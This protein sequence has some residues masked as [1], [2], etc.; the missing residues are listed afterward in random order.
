MILRDK[1]LLESS[2]IEVFR[3]EI[4][5]QKFGPVQAREVDPLRMFAL[6]IFQI[7]LPLGCV[8]DVNVAKPPV[9]LSEF[10]P[11]KT[12]TEHWVL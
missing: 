8:F 10:Y 12:D 7:R 5:K 4:L 11:R 1:I 9:R 2:L 6:P 3:W